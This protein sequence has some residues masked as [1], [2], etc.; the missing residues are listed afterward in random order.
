[1]SDRLA[2]SV[3]DAAKA[4]GVSKSTFWRL[5]AGGEVHTFKLGARTL[6]RAEELHALIARH[7]DRAAA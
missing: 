4:I 3:P 5:I 7:D 1:M 2:Y 6:V